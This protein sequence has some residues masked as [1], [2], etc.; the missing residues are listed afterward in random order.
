[1]I[2]LHNRA[3]QPGRETPTVKRQTL[4]GGLATA[5]AGRAPR[6]DPFAL[7]VRF[8]ARDAAA[9]GRVRDVEIDHDGVRL[10]RRLRG[11]LINVQVPIGNFLG[12]AVRLVAAEVDAEESFAVSLEHRDPALTVEL[13]VAPENSD[14]MAAWQCWA[15]V[16]GL[17]LLVADRT[18]ALRPPYP[19]L[20]KVQ[21]G[22][23][24]GRRRRKNAVSKR[25]PRLSLRRAMGETEKPVT[26]HHEREIVARD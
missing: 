18:G 23:P 19:M 9:D 4:L 1:M 11:M 14:I 17:P 8:A 5:G 16:L 10:R 21:V 25:R 12:V 22:A 3:E 6:P 26:V 24:G 2:C 15:R 13:C 7:P 20:G